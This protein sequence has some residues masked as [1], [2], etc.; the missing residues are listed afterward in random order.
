VN[1]D[2]AREPPPVSFAVVTIGASAGGV[3]ALQKIAAGLDAQAPA[4]YFVVIHVGRHPSYLPSILNA[5]GMVPAQFAEHGAVIVPGRI[6]VA[7]PDRHLLL[8]K[9]RMFLSRG[10][11]ENR[12]RPAIDPLFRSAAHRFGGRAIGVVLTGL[13]DDGTAGLRQIAICRGTT[14]VQ[15]PGEAECPDMPASAVRHVAVDHWL[16]LAAIPPLLSTLAREI[17]KRQREEVR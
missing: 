16:P 1:Q 14:V 4:A 5:A 15:D 10:P 11:R 13:L 7:P 3:A 8:S 6:F 17:V 2:I 9:E 12:S